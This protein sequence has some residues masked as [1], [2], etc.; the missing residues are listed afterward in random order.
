MSSNTRILFHGALLI[1]CGALSFSWTRQAKDLYLPSLLHAYKNL[2]VEISPYFHFAQ[3]L[4]P[5]TLHEFYIPRLR[6]RRELLVL[7]TSYRRL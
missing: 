3:R 4:P 7:E 2:S 1:P 5:V 6:S